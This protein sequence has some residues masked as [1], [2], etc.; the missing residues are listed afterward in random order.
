[1]LLYVVGS[2]PETEM[3]R[4]LWLEVSDSIQKLFSQSLEKINQEILYS[5][6]I[7]NFGEKFWVTVTADNEFVFEIPPFGLQL[8]GW[9][10]AE[11]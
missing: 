6:V 3:P 7:G 4:N 2:K 9:N 5:Q 11:G 1:M 8:E 10:K